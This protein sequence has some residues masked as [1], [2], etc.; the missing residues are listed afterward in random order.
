MFKNYYLFSELLKEIQPAISGQKITS[1]FTYRKDEVVLELGNGQFILIG[2]AANEPYLLLK[3]A[4]NISQARYA[5]FEKLYGQTIRNAGLLNFDKHLFI[6]TESY[7]LE[8]IFFPPHNNVFL[9][10]ADRQI[11]KAFKDKTEYPAKLPETQEKLD[12]R[13]IEASLLNDLIV[14]NPTL[15]VRGF[16]QN[17]F[18]ALNKVMLNEILFRTQLD[19][20][21]ALSELN[22]EQKERLISVLLKIKEELTAGK[23]YL[24]FD[25]YADLIRWIS[26]IRL[27]QF[28]E[29]YDF[30]E[31]DSINHALGVFY[32]EKRVRQEF[33][34]LKALCK[35]ALQK[36]LRFL[37]SSLE[38]LKEHADLRKRK[39]EAE[40]KGNLLLTFKND[41][42]PGAREV[43]LA[44]I[45][46]ERQEKIKIKLNPSKSVV[47][48]A[49]RYF[50]KFKNVQH[51]QQ[52]LQIKMDTYRREM[53]EIDQL[54]KQLEQIRTLQRLKS[55]SDR[56]REM[57]LI[58]D[59]S[60]SNKKAA[61]ENLKYVFNRL[62]LD[63][64]WEVYIGRDGKTNDL[65]TFHFANKWDIWLHAQGV[66]GAHVIIRVPNRN[67]TPPAHVIEQAARIAAAHSKAR[68]SS[69]VPVIYTQVRYVSRIRK[70][71]P[72]TVKFQN[73]KV[74]FVSPMNLN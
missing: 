16:L 74:L 9:L 66:S 24:Y 19:P 32:Y 40:L 62:I 69:T 53:E 28:Q 44:N 48:N 61:P 52:V 22:E 20:E 49:Q 25:K 55:F 34:K 56:L 26:L 58:Q 67:Q 57:K 1:A 27:E 64:K 12:L 47:E 39:T 21:Q 68:T 72:G 33:E 51:N 45:F 23:A 2:I 38:R 36:R 60:A 7:R 50:N 11:L 14:K 71:P 6:E 70:A 46:S 41:I 8:A 17:H 59:G 18:A 65:L 54:L 10:S 42:P 29:S 35:T 43:E 15:K 31:Y 4:H 63:G 37:N 3:A 73:E 13:G 30:K 5:L